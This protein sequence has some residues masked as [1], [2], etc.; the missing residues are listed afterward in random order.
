MVAW[1]L[2]SQSHETPAIGLAA[3]RR[4]PVPKPALRPADLTDVVSLGLPVSAAEH[5]CYNDRPETG[6]RS[7]EARRSERNSHAG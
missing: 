5:E 4:E 2:G 6:D 3:G 1:R 7:V